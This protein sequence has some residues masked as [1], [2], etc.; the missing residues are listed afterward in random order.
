[1]LNASLERVKLL[2]N[3]HKDSPPMKSVLGGRG[4]ELVCSA[5][6]PTVTTTDLQ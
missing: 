3:Q 4:L 5:L 1:M 2:S 6:L